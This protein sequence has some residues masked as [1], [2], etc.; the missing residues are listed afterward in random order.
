[1]ETIPIMCKIIHVDFHPIMHTIIKYTQ[2]I[3]LQGGRGI[4]Q[5]KWEKF[6]SKVPPWTC[7]CSIDPIL[8]NYLDLVVPVESI[9]EGEEIFPT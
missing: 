9:Q 1:M 5:A 7:E 4:A 3:P 8:R 2:H 6:I